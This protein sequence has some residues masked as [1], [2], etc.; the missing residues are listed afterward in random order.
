MADRNVDDDVM[1]SPAGSCIPS[2]DDSCAGMHT[3]Y[4]MDLR[5]EL[6]VIRQSLT[7]RWRAGHRPYVTAAAVAAVITFWML[8]HAG[9]W[10]N[11]IDWLSAVRADQPLLASLLRVP[12]SILVPAPDLPVWGAVGQ[13]AVIGTLGEL[14]LGRRRLIGLALG[15]QFTATMAG[16]IATTFGPSSVGRGRV[17]TRSTCP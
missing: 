8:R 1:S 7:G 14:L 11:P 17:I 4:H 10:S 13:V 12:L 15:V 6:T 3:A 9:V 5:A 16:R 2:I